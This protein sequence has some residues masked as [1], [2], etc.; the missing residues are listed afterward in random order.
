MGCYEYGASQDSDGDLL[1]DEQELLGNTDPTRDD[2]DGEG[3]RD[4]LEIL[5]GTDPLV[6]TSP[7]T[8]GVPSDI[9]TIQ[10][11][12]CL[13]LNGETI[14]VAPGTYRENVHFCGTELVVRGSGTAGTQTT[15]ATII[16]GAASSPAV[17]FTGAESGACVLSGFV[18][19]NGKAYRG[20]GISGGNSANHTHATIRDNVI[21]GNKSNYG[22]GLA[23][24]NGRM[25][26]NTIVANAASNDGGG[27]QDC[28][29]IIR[30]CIIW[31][32][33]AAKSGSQ[34]HLSE[35]FSFSCIQDWTE[36][37]EGLA[38]WYDRAGSSLSSDGNIADDPL[39]VDPDGPDN[40]PKTYD[41]NDYRL[42]PD[43]PCIDAGINE[44]WM[45]ETL[46]PDGKA[47]ILKGASSLTV[48]MGAYEFFRPTIVNVKETDE[49]G[50][51]LTW[52]SQANDS[53]VIF[54]S[55][56]LATGAWVEEA[57][58]PSQGSTTFWTDPAPV[59]P[60]KF[61]RVQMK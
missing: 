31:A 44:D 43:S 48:D 35:T 26:N 17:R 42:L 18:I 36:G 37:G 3:L 8:I 28:H 15:D 19:T 51:E 23:L 2:T 7:G 27:L 39:F 56:D 11:A 20:G 57:T 58:V 41:D 16:N 21:C 47:R 40:A 32:N 12:L 6:P 53:Y 5:R 61:Y 10:A 22:A 1:S 25:E 9:P 34:L 24:C 49:E 38:L 60:I 4:G 52:T 59:V 33:T 55:A 54:S 46:D 29:G 13:A 45:W 50:V 30:N 14:V